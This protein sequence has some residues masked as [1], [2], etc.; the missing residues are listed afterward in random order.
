MASESS[1]V[2]WRPQSACHVQDGFQLFSYCF[3]DQ[4][5]RRLSKQPGPTHSTGTG[6]PVFAREEF[7]LPSVLAL[8]CDSTQNMFLPK[9]ALRQESYQIQLNI[10]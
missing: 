3:T 5:Y 6:Q 8:I 2:H 9:Q 7:V 10:I 1:G 4:P